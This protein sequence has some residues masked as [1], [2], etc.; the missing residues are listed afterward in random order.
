LCLDIGNDVTDI[1][2]V[3]NLSQSKC[4]ERLPFGGA[5]LSN[6]MKALI[7]QKYGRDLS[8]YLAHNLKEKFCYVSE[9]Y[10][11]EIKKIEKEN[12]SSSAPRFVLPD[13]ESVSV[14]SERIECPEALFDPSV[15]GS[16]GLGLSSRLAHA[17]QQLPKSFT[18]AQKVSIALCG[19]TT[20]MKGLKERLELDLKQSMISNFEV[21]SCV[22]F[23]SSSSSSSSSSDT[24]IS[25]W[26][27]GS[28]SSKTIYFQQRKITKDNCFCM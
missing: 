27:G 10:Q 5:T 28:L 18:Q 16:S 1:S 3:E 21:I 26:C 4:L 6:H 13:G 20:K 11:K 12:L 25:I 17:I 15:L 2:F 8:S 9:N 23:S 19:G 22:P 7:Q 14:G 24:D